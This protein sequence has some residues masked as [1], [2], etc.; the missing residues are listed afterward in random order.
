MEYVLGALGTCLAT[1][2][3]FNAT[4]RGIAIEN[5]EVVLE[6]T[7]TSVPPPRKM[8]SYGESSRV[9]VCPVPPSSRT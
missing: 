9:C 4:Q 8:K 6:S 7:M 1:G 2:F 5:L 3:V